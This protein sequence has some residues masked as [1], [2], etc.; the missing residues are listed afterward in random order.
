MEKNKKN[1]SLVKDEVK[2]QLNAQLAPSLVKDE[3]KTIKHQV[4]GTS[5][6]KDEEKNNTQRERQKQKDED[7]EH[8]KEVINFYIRM[9]QLPVNHARGCYVHDYLPALGQTCACVRPTP[10]ILK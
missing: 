2:K 9:Q 7:E 3:G 10:Q 4:R 6:V 5:Q 8:E 1:A